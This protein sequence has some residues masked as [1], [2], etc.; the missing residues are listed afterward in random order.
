MRIT[1]LLDHF[2]A[3]SETFVVNELRAIHALGHDVH[4][5]TG[6]WAAERAAEPSPVPVSCLDEDGLMRRM[7]DLAWLLARHPLRCLHDGRDR[8]AW[9]RDEPVRPLRVIAPEVR[10][11]ARRR[12]DH[13]HVHFAAG[14]ALDALRI[15]RLLG[16]P[17]S[18][19][20]HAYDIYRAPRNLELKLRDAAF[21]AGVSEYSV[22]DLRRIA[23]E[24]HAGDV[25]VVV[26]GVDHER[27]RRRTPYPGGR[28]VV[29]IGRLVE[30][31]GIT[32]LLDA[33]AQADVERLVV[34]GD[35]PLR[36]PLSDRARALGI[37]ARVDWRGAQSVDEVRAAL[38]EADVLA[39]TAV[40]VADGDRDVLPVVVGE[41]LSMGL[42]V[43][44]S[45]F[46]GLPEVVRAPWGRL[47]PPGDAAAIAGALDDILGRPREERVEMGRAGREFVVQTRD[48]AA[49]AR[50]LT[51]LM[52]QV[53]AVG[54]GS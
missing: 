52:A 33:V 38:E 21:A 10:R 50:H 6:A 39:M 53:R 46:V 27:F 43:V 18:V 45:D 51:E 4:I 54:R 13:I 25:H 49:S 44:A 22:G 5:E 28:T 23:G 17:Y 7:V 35:G 2:P 24:R 40:P 16:L 31:K 3:I 14:A 37:E 1:V 42:P 11:I 48:L 19:T 30:K 26:M 15:G 41:A 34:I 32:H 9:R 47:V 29:T 36:E 12:T 8:R 20:A